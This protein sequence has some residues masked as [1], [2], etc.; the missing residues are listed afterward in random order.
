MS[1]LSRDKKRH[2]STARR[3]AHPIPPRVIITD[4]TDVINIIDIIELG[5]EGGAIEENRTE[6]KSKKYLPVVVQ[7]SCNR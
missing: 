1:N 7:H 6:A 4:I 3:T 2:K 5:G